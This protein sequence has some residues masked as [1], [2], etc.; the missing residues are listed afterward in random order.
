MFGVLL[1]YLGTVKLIIRGPR[2]QQLLEA[3]STTECKYT[4]FAD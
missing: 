1:C 2:V 4:F 3:F